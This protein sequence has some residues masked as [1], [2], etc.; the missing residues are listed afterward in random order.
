VCTADSTALRRPNIAT[1]WQDI[2]YGVRMLRKTP[3]F[4]A[5]AILTL[6]LGI[7]ANTAI[8]SLINALLWKPLSGVQDPQQLMRVTVRPWPFLSYPQYEHFCK[9]NQ[10]LSGL[11]AHAGQ[12]FK[13]RMRVTGSDAA[14]AEW[15]WAPP[16]SGNFFSV[17]GVPALLGR[18]LTPE[19]DRPGDPEPVAVIS[20]DLWCRRFGQDPAVIGRTITLDAAPLTIVGVAP[21]E[22]TGFIVGKRPDLWWPLQMFPQVQGADSQYYLTNKGTLWLHIGGRLRRGV[23]AAQAQE[24]LNVLFRQM[25]LAWVGELGL[26]G[27]K[28]QDF[29]GFRIELQSAGTGFTRLRGEFQRLLSVLMAMVGVVLLVACMNLAGLLLARGAARQRELTLRAALGASRPALMRQLMTESLLLAAVGG[30]LGLL[31]AQWGVRL[32]ATYIRQSG[33]IARLQLT[34]DWRILA[35]AFLISLATA[36]LFGLVPAWR[37]SRLDV[38]TALKDQ[39]ASVLGLRPAHV[40]NKGLI[41][42]QVALSCC[43]LI[44]AGLFVRTVQKLRALDTGFDRENLMVFD[45]YWPK[46]YDDARAGNLSEEV[47]QRVRN[48]PGVRSATVANILALGDDEVQ[49]GM[50]KVAVPVTGATGGESMNI[51]ATAVGL[52]YFQTMGIPLLMGRDFGPQDEPPAEMARPSPSPRPVI[53]DQASARRLF[54]DEN[55]IGML[56]NTSG[57]AL[58]PCLEVIGVAGDVMYE[59]LRKGPTLSV[60]VLETCRTCSSLVHFH[61]RTA[62][63]PFAVADGIRR[64]VHE[65]DPQVEVTGLRTVGD[66]VNEQL[67]RERM[68][69]QLAGFFSLSAL[70]LACLGLYGVLSCAVTR[71]TREIGIRMALGAQR[72]NVLSVVVRQGMMLALIGCVLGVSL[73]VALTR[74][75]SSL[76]YGVTPTDPLTFVV[77]VLLLGTVAF[78][79]SWL[80]ARR[81]ARIDPMAALRY[82]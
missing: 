73:A 52:G 47:L 80:P 48:L 44:G 19:D 81:A 21:P 16:V 58:W 25:L 71:R 65:L 6:A 82:E 55:P 49:W 51:H 31:L 54:G 1:L 61:I 11:F 57:W 17:L 20:H 28:R 36:L 4:A 9:A 70:A 59:D 78:V 35:F 30:T 42:A 77:T 76:L 38:M 69:S 79:S 14:E 74:V 40:G 10:S 2:R 27:S 39:A 29:L 32:P 46:E 43:L 68:L 63:R 3:G 26:S 66:L 18:M 5:V 41:V 7:G 64:V 15:V 72:H 23:A 12:E 24:E 8:F 60:Y 13:R 53:V 67:R 62:G 22:F 37:S 75:V 33:E 34:P 50:R 56:L 45:L